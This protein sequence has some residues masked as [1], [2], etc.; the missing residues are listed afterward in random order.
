MKPAVL[1][2]LLLSLAQAQ[3]PAVSGEPKELLRMTI[4]D[5]EPGTGPAAAAGQRYKVH[6]TGWLRD[7]TKFDSSRDRSEPLTFVQGRRQ[8][9][10][11]WEAGFAGMNVGG[12]RRLIIPYQMAYGDKGSGK[13]IPPKA[14]LIFDVELLGVEDVKEAPAASDILDELAIVQKK[15]I[16]MAESLPEEKFA[17]RP[18]AGVRSFGE[19]FRHVRNDN[20][21]WLSMVGRTPAPEETYK[22]WAENSK[23]EKQ[24]YTRQETIRDL[25]ESFEAVRKAIEPMRS[26]ALGADVHALDRDT[27]RRGVLVMFLTH[28]SEH[29]GQLIAYERVNG[30]VPPWS[31]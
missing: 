30:I 11:G 9:I 4:V 16:D 20:L 31:K 14:D 23:S 21:V 19:V 25:R 1:F 10:A 7:G 17:W 22:L 5:I 26:G 15:M 13:V 27:T 8:V 18:A 3:I 28:A 29:L 12:K 6:Y 24:T 2:T